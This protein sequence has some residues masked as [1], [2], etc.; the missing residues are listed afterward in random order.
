MLMAVRWSSVA[1]CVSQVSPLALRACPCATKLGLKQSL[2]KRGKLFVLMVLVFSGL[3]SL[4]TN[5][6]TTSAYFPTRLTSNIERL[7]SGGMYV[8]YVSDI[9]A[10]VGR[11]QTVGRVFQFKL[12]PQSCDYPPHSLHCIRLG[13]KNTC[14][15]EFHH[16][17]ISSYV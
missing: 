10:A 14:T 1:K 15:S 17:L 13:P 11:K 9:V 7:V 12:K 2:A 16:I 5:L 6:V 4:L 3:V 8:G